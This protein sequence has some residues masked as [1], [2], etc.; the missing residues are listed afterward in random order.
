MITPFPG[1]DCTIWGGFQSLAVI[2]WSKEVWKILDG[3]K[4]RPSWK[5]LQLEF[6]RSRSSPSRMSS[7]MWGA[8]PDTMGSFSALHVGWSP[9]CLQFSMLVFSFQ[10]CFF[11][12]ECFLLRNGGNGK[13][14]GF[15][16][17]LQMF[18][19]SSMGRKN[20]SFSFSS[21]TFPKW[22][23]QQAAHSP[24]VY[25][26]QYSLLSL[27]LLE[28]R[29]G[30]LLNNRHIINSTSCFMVLNI[31][32]SRRRGCLLLSFSYEETSEALR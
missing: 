16:L 14:H 27:F 13:Q 15:P 21:L 23:L 8:L 10:C 7:S 2:I 18:F 4:L 30:T 26:M 17:P 12:N 22:C 29:W 28:D 24:C 9:V 5:T 1:L 19:L 3:I 6:T 20:L 31:Y 11:L 25:P 32:M